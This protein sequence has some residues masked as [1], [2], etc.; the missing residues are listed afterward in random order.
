[1]LQAPKSSLSL[2]QRSVHHSC[3]QLWQVYEVQTRVLYSS[4]S[5]S[6]QAVPSRPPHPC[7]RRKQTHVA[8]ASFEWACRMKPMKRTSRYSLVEQLLRTPPDLRRIL[9]GRTRHG[10]R[11]AGQLQ[12]VSRNKAKEHHRKDHHDLVRSQTNSDQ[13]QT[14]LEPDPA[15]RCSVAA[16]PQSNHRDVGLAIQSSSELPLR[17]PFSS[18]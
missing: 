13:S 15:T 18:G 6:G 4:A 1:M 7:Q 3:E 17:A 8:L 9:P 14:A 12:L 11:N 10:R 16:L 2:W 5:H